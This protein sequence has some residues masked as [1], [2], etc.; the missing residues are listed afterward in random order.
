MTAIHV[1]KKTENESVLKIYST[2]PAGNTYQIELNSDYIKLPTE[3]YVEGQSEVTI[4]EFFWGAK[5]NKQLDISRVANTVA[6]TAHGHY[7]LYGT[8]HY[9][10]VGFVDNTYSNSAVRITSDGAFH[11]L[12]KLK[13]NGY[14]L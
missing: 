5:A 12:I 1:L 11:L 3:T 9:N 13:K 6:N 10:F 14:E 4:Q 8:G 2:S 7:Y